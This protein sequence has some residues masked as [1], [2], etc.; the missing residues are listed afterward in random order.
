MQFLKGLK[1]GGF[2][3]GNSSIWKLVHIFWTLFNHSILASVLFY[4]VDI[5]KTMDKLIKKAGSL[6]GMPPDTECECVKGLCY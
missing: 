4:A 3:S 5:R 2:S 1:P 6:I